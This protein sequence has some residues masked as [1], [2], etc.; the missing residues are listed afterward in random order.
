METSRGRR[1]RPIG[2]RLPPTPGRF[3]EVDLVELGDHRTADV[4]QDT[5]DPIG[6]PES[7]G[8]RAPVGGADADGEDRHLGHPVELEDRVQR[9]LGAFPVRQA[10]AWRVTRRRSFTAERTHRHL[11]SGREVGGRIADVIGRCLHPGSSWKVPRSVVGG[12]CRNPAPPKITRPIRSPGRAAASCQASRLAA[13]E[14]RVSPTSVARIERERSS[15]TMRSRPVR[16]S[17]AGCRPHCGRAS[18][19]P[20]QRRERSKRRDGAAAGREPTGRIELRASKL[21][22]AEVGEGLPRARRSACQHD[23][24]RRRQHQQQQEGRGSAKSSWQPPKPGGL[25]AASRAG[26]GRGP[27]PPTVGR[28][29]GIAGSRSPRLRSAPAD[30]SRS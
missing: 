14:A 10:A 18:A 23:D 9:S 1:D 21:W 17:G 30:R 12:S 24:Q 8:T 2:H 11:E 5:R 7:A 16:A 29:R 6:E 22:C 25:A 20:A 13:L 26:G 3:S 28:A 19:R 4:V 15:A 27:Y